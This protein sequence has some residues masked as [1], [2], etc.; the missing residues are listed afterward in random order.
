M[1]TGKASSPS[2]NASDVA[3]VN[4]FVRKSAFR[5]FDEEIGYIGEDTSLIASLLPHVIYHSGVRVFH[6][7]R[8]F[9]GP[10]LRQRWRYR[11]KTGEMLARGAAAVCEEPE[12]QGVSHRRRDRDH[13][14]SDHRR[15]VLRLHAHPRFAND[16]AAN[17]LLAAAA[18]RVRR[19]SRHV[20]CRHRLGLDSSKAALEFLHDSLTRHLRPS[21]RHRLRHHARA[22]G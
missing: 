1:R 8:A 15:S 17:A 22:S 9:P 19:A 18:V 5:G 13:R 2:T 16:A 20:L 3:L 6:R 12:D 14:R 7:R 4:L 10:Y 11:V 21:P